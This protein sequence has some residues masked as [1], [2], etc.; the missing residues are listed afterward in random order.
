MSS[1]GSLF[2]LPIGD[3]DEDPAELI[4]FVG[5]HP[6]PVAPKGSHEFHRALVVL[7]VFQLNDADRRKELFQAR[8]LQLRAL[9]NE[10]ENL[11]T[12]R[13]ASIRNAAQ[14]WIDFYVSP[15]CP[16]SSCMRS[17]VVVYQNN[18]NRAKQLMEQAQT[19][20]H[21]GSLPA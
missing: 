20:I 4:R 6:E 8:G 13:T 16:H 21:T 11:R 12:A 19:F 17:F 7:E 10:L 1:E 14:E 9:F 2:I 18:R 5:M 3:I 15:R